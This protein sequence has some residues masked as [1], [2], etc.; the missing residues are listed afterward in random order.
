[1]NQAMKIGRGFQFTLGLPAGAKAHYADKG[2]KKDTKNRPIFW[3]LPEGSKRF[4]VLDA[5]TIRDA[6]KAPR[7]DGAM[8]LR[9]KTGASK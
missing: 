6:N 5:L 3:Y 2:V 4:R 7:I 8:P 9:R 1:M